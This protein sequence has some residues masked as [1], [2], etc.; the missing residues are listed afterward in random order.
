[1]FYVTALTCFLPSL[2]ALVHKSED[3]LAPGFDPSLLEVKQYIT[4]KGQ[5]PLLASP[6]KAGGCSTNCHSL[7]NRTIK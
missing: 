6:G 4:I 5:L 3:Y 1:M 2:A 7:I